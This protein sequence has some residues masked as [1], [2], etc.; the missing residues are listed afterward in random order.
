MYIVIE[1]Q[2]TENA[3]AIVPPATYNTMD[4]AD[5][6][7]HTQLAAASVSAV[8]VHTVFMVNEYGDVLKAETHTH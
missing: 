4:A 7:Y 1:L 8:P 6:A 5:A 3:M 2:K